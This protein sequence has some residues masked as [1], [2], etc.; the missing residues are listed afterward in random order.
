MDSVRTA[1]KSEFEK[2]CAEQEANTAD[3]AL[4][5]TVWLRKVVYP[6]PNCGHITTL[7]PPSLPVLFSILSTE[8]P[9]Y[10]EMI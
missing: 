8:L 3:A 4:V 6:D 9:I 7:L 5:P 2:L 10:S 1:Q